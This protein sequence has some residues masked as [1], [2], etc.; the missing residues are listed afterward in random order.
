MGCPMNNSAPNI[1]PVENTPKNEGNNMS[2]SYQGVK[3]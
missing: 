1:Q 3:P 2:V